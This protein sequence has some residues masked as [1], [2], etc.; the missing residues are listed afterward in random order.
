MDGVHELVTRGTP[1]VHRQPD[2]LG[3]STGLTF[4]MIK[5]KPNTGLIWV[6]CQAF[7]T[8]TYLA[9]SRRP[10]HIAG[11]DLGVEEENARGRRHLR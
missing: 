10:R 3:I 7:K 6:E 8:V 5:P 1:H 2:D 4:L 11:G 9:N